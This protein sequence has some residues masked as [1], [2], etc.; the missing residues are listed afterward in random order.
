MK[1]S[2]F[3]ASSEHQQQRLVFSGVLAESAAHRL[4]SK[5]LDYWCSSPTSVAAL[6]TDYYYISGIFTVGLIISMYGTAIVVVHQLEYSLSCML[7]RTHTHTHKHSLSIYIF[8]SF[9]CSP[10]ETENLA[11]RW[12]G[13]RQ[14]HLKPVTSEWLFIWIL[15]PTV[16]HTGGGTLRELQQQECKYY[17]ENHWDMKCSFN[18]NT[19]I[20]RSVSQRIRRELDLS[21]CCTILR[22]IPCTHSLKQCIEYIIYGT[23]CLYKGKMYDDG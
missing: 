11:V 10:G 4:L 18:Y 9:T 3:I 15:L 6:L 5:N 8:T 12:M 17:G 13:V 20:S 16:S 1:R 23:T 21:F 19:D 14:R 22:L 7:T 2:S